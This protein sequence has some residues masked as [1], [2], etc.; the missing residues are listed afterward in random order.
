MIR[1][2]ANRTD[3]TTYEF[4]NIIMK[5]VM[6]HANGLDHWVNHDYIV[7]ST[8]ITAFRAFN[9]M[10]TSHI[11]YNRYHTPLAKTHHTVADHF[12]FLLSNQVTSIRRDGGG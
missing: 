7:N 3:E 8:Q 4:P 11:L 6:K 9:T 1:I 12:F 10:K 5:I 2:W